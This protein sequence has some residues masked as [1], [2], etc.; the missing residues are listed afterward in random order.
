MLAAFNFAIFFPLLVVAVYRLP[1]G[2]A[3]AVGGLQPLLGRAALVAGDAARDRGPSTSS[4]AS[5][6]RSAWV[7]WSSARRAVDGLGL[8][9]AVGANV[10]FAI[11]VVLTKRFPAPPNRLAATGWQLLLGGAVLVPLTLLVEGPPP[12]LTGGHVA[13][14]AYLSIAGTAMAFVLWF[15]GIRRLPAAA[16]PLLGL[17]AP[18]TGAVLGL[19]RARPVAVARAADRVRHHHR[20]HRLRRVARPRHDGPGDHRAGP[21]QRPP[22]ARRAW[23]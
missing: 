12:A 21:G 18:I 20:R 4:S 19:G 7:S 6:P 10:S 22:A 8:A 14:F 1:G 23:L 13:G 9:A 11:G 3:A 17:A 15:N 2:V 5:S 16:P